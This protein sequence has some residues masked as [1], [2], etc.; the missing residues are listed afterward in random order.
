MGLDKNKLKQGLIDNYNSGAQDGERTQQDSSKEMAR[1][2]VD[3]ASDA[4][5]IIVGSPPLIPV[6]PPAVPTPDASVMGKKVKVATAKSGEKVLQSGIDGSFTAQDPT[7]M[8]M[9]TAIQSYVP[10]SFTAFNN[11]SIL[12]PTINVTGAAVMAVPPLLSPAS[13]KGMAGGSVEDVSDVMATAIHTAFI[14]T[15]F[16]GS[17]VHLSSGAVIPGLISGTL[18]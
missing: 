17:V 10:M 12:P 1:V 15:L 3:Y 2:I 16:T 11:K 7:L 6:P 9:A 5:L 18:I 4:E 8:L 14:A 13:A